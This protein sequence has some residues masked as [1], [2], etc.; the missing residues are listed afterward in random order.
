MTS[1][2]S[3]ECVSS[4]RIPPAADWVADG[5]FFLVALA[6]AVTFWGLT[7]IC[8]EYCVPAITVF[9]K[10]NKISDDIAG[11]IFI[12]TGLSL[13]VLFAS[14]V[15]LFISNNAIGVGTVVGGDIFNHLVNI[16]ASIH[17]AP[18]RTLKLDAVTFTR[19]MVFYILSCLAVVWVA[20]G[21]LHNSFASMFQ[22][23]EWLSCLSIH[24]TGAFAL[25]GFYVLYC[26]V[27]AYFGLLTATLSRC[28]VLYVKSSIDRM[29]YAQ[30]NLQ[31]DRGSDH[32]SDGPDEEQA[33]D[34]LF[35]DG[36]GMRRRGLSQ[37]SGGSFD[38]GT[39]EAHFELPPLIHDDFE[40]SIVATH[41]DEALAS[42][43]ALSPQNAAFPPPPPPPPPRHIAELP[44]PLIDLDQ[45][46]NQDDDVDFGDFAMYMRSSFYAAHAIGCIPNSRAWKL[47]HFTLDTAGLYYRLER[48]LPKRGPHV[49]FID[50]FDL[51]DVRVTNHEL[52]EFSIRLRERQKAYYFRGC[53]QHSFAALVHRLTDLLYDIKKRNESELRAMALKSM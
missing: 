18:N 14:F 45:P 10:R 33:E 44:R 9:C 27:D 37:R 53:D 32:M 6:V 8:E 49:R 20:K 47:R 25:V 12:G 36:S 22:R 24:W 28:Y 4:E 7:F 26:V 34:I 42:A 21:N 15:G 51:E 43:F 39:G 40:Q 41:N 16:A 5:G 29:M 1:T 38:A 17:A 48:H 11:A 31:S 50:V 3:S 52:F 2:A 46:R 30:A 19:E 35:G 23:D 13:P